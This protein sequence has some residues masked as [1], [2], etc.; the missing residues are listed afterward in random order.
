M[1]SQPLNLAQGLAFAGS[2]IDKSHNFV[3]KTD[4]S[5]KDLRKGDIFLT[6]GLNFMGVKVEQL[7]RCPRRMLAR[8]T[9]FLLTL[10]ST[11]L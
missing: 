6:I 3:S 8:Y 5:E 10:L 7:T 4:G 2:R 11:Y 9:Y 1:F